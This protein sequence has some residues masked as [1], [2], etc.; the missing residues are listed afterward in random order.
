[1]QIHHS[2]FM[3]D[4]WLFMKVAKHLDRLMHRL[5]L[6]LLNQEATQNLRYQR[7]NKRRRHRLNTSASLEHLRR[8]QNQQFKNQSQGFHNNEPTDRGHHVCLLPHRRYRG[9]RHRFREGRPRS[10]R[11][12]R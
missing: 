3:N 6:G 5:Y 10:T 8:N 7:L 9:S 12:L 11:V 2:G 4:S 1:M